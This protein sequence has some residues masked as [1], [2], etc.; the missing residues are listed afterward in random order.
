MLLAASD[1]LWLKEQGGYPAK[2]LFLIRTA[3][4]L[5]PAPFPPLPQLAHAS[6]CSVFSTALF[7]SGGVSRILRFTLQKYRRDV[8]K[9]ALPNAPLGHR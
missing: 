1:E 6:S 8:A 2:T 3:S 5:P 4:F 7:H 9:R